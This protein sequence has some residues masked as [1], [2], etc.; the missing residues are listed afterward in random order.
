MWILMVKIFVRKS[1]VPTRTSV[2][3]VGIIEEV[4]TNWKVREEVNFIKIRKLL[5]IIVLVL[6]P[7]PTMKVSFEDFEDSTFFSMLLNP[8]W[9]T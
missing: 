1:F 7:Q 6:I 5:T 8:N 9:I 2:R 3:R 4:M